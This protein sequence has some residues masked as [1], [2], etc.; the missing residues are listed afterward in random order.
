M[1]PADTEA[2]AG[3]LRILSRLVIVVIVVIL[4]PHDIAPQD[5]LAAR[6]G[7]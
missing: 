2:Y 7:W 1:S 4:M 3:W 6:A 5:I